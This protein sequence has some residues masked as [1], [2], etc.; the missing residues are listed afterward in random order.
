MPQP[1][2][3][4]SSTLGSHRAF[5][6]CFPGNCPLLLDVQCLETIVPYICLLFFQVDSGRR[7]NPISTGPSCPEAE[8][9]NAYFDKQTHLAESVD[10]SPSCVFLSP[11]PWTI[12]VHCHSRQIWLSLNHIT[13]I[14][15][16]VLIIESHWLKCWGYKDKWKQQPQGERV[17][18]QPG[19]PVFSLSDQQ[20]PFSSLRQSHILFPSLQVLLLLT[21]H[22]MCLPH[23]NEG[24]FL[25]LH[26]PFP[27]EIK[28][29][30]SCHPSLITGKHF[31]LS[32][33]QAYT[34]SVILSLH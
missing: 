24:E 17:C 26:T 13:F 4:P 16:Y 22:S 15:F 6:I 27:Y 3:S 18:G 1:G 30:S 20:S 2:N 10:F 28:F 9:R 8:V 14:F 11:P 19:F 34:Y 31:L 32:I 33:I 25:K 23:S 5:L 29:F 7:V 21:V 12:N